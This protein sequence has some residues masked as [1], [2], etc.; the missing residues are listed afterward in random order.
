MHTT[1]DT[2]STQHVVISMCVWLVGVGHGH[3]SAIIILLCY[4]THLIPTLSLVLFLVLV[5]YCTTTSCMCRYT[6]H[7]L[8]RKTGNC[9][10]H[11]SLQLLQI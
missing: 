7:V 5:H 4:C 10:M 3:V 11:Q 6:V 8:M 2:K 9:F 1:L